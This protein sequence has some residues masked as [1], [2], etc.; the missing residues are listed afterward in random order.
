MKPPPASL[1]DVKDFTVAMLGCAVST[2]VAIGVPV[3]IVITFFALA[4]CGWEAGR[5]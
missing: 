5:P 2:V 3:L 4:R 1:E